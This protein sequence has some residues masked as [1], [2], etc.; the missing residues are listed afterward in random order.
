MGSGKR[1]TRI[2]A[3]HTD[4]SE[5]QKQGCDCEADASAIARTMHASTLLLFNPLLSL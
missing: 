2:K 4:Q 5:K 1:L 3:D